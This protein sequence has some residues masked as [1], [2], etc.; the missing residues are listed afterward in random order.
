L[1]LDKYA[2]RK[3]KGKQ[4]EDLYNEIDYIDDNIEGFTTQN[5]V[6]L[7]NNAIVQKES[8]TRAASLIEMKEKA[9][10]H[11]YDSPLAKIKQAVLDL[12]P[13]LFAVILGIIAFLND[14]YVTN[15]INLNF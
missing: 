3:N 7:L 1:E 13:G 12:V 15:I 5:D 14:S 11:R 10:E 2:N 4:R 8:K 9:L 6:T